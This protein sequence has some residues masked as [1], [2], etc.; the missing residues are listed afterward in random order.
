M[1]GAM[2]VKMDGNPPVDG[3]FLNPWTEFLLKS[4]SVKAY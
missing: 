4:N 1:A 2:V 3:S